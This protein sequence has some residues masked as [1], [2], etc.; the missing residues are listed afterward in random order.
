MVEA[1][2]DIF[3][4]PAEKGDTRNL[5]KTP[6]TAER[7]PSW[8]PDGK[9]IAYFSDASGEYQLYIRD[10]DG[11]QPP[12]VIDLG[13]DPSFFYSPTLVARL[14]AHRLLRQASASLVRR[15]R[16]WQAGQDRHR[17]ARRLRLRRLNFPGR[18]TRSG[19][20][21]PATW[22]TSCTPSSSIRWPRTR[23]TQITDGMSNAAHPVFDPGGK[24]LYFTASTNNGPSDAGIDLSSLDRATTSSAYVI[25]LARDGSIADPARKRRREQEEE[26][27]RKS[28]KKDDKKDTTVRKRAG[29]SEEK[30]ED[31]KPKPTVIDLAGIGNRILSLPIP[32]RN[33]VDLSV[34]KTGV[35]FLAE[36]DA[37]RPCLFRRRTTDPVTLALHHGKAQDEEVL[38]GLNGYTVSFNGEKLF[39]MR[40]DN[41]FLAPIADLK[42]GAPEAP[43]GQTRQ[44]RW[45]D[46]HDRS[47]RRVE[48]DVPRDL[49]HRA[50]LLLRSASSRRR[51]RQR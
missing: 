51:P 13:P 49:A 18:P 25:V 36:G 44:Q 50:R 3:T 9:S 19:S 26:E 42:P 10:Q 43:Q 35:L 37:G 16:R 41:W 27:D 21:T 22:R 5:T 45:H 14:Q 48:A 28:D 8:S 23:S 6:G 11:L 39:Y 15:R 29:R 31:E 24:Y 47:A 7:D 17:H 33:Y 1:H 20:P 12:K 34:G 40:G 4:L 30:K 46:G 32:A 38:S 2:G